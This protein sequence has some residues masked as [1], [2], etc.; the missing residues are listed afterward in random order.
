MSFEADLFYERRN[1]ILVERDVSVPNFTG[2]SLPDENYGIVD[3]K[4]FEAVIGYKDRINELRYSLEGNFAF[5]RNK[6]IEADEPERPV[7]WQVQTGKPQGAHLLYKAIGIFDDWDEVNSTPHVTGAA[8]G[9]IIIEDY[10]GDGKIT[11]ADRQ[12]FPLTTTPEMTFGMNFNLNYK[13][14]E[15]TGLFQGHARTWRRIN[16]NIQQG[17]SG[18]YFMYDAEDRWTAENPDGTKPK[19]FNWSEEYWRSSH[20]TTYFYHDMSFVRLKNLQL[21]YNIPNSLMNRIGAKNTRVYVSGQNLCLIWA[22]QNIMDPEQRNGMSSYPL[23]R[24]IALGAQ[25]SF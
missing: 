2:I 18:N 6:V 9:D 24:V 10:D 22:A 7:P 14:W 21:S 17:M 13:N 3:N 25:I 15:L 8:P 5:V 19:A 12:L 11:G 1:N 16:N 4:G 20:I 23:M